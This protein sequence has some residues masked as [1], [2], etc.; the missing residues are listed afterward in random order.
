MTAR[1]VFCVQAYFRRDRRLT[2]GALYEFDSGLDAEEAG[3]E[4]SRAADGVLVYAVE[5]EPRYEVWGEPVIFARYGET[6]RIEY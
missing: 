5:C 3:R 2:P 6:P 4:L 1:T